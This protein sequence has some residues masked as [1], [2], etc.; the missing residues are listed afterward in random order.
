MHHFVSQHRYTMSPRRQDSEET[1]FDGSSND[2]SGH[3][4]LDC[5]PLDPFLIVQP[6]LDD[7]LL[8]KQGLVE[9]TVPP[10]PTHNP[11]DIQ[12]PPS[13]VGR[14][15]NTSSRT[16]SQNGTINISIPQSRSQRGCI[17]PATPTC[18]SSPREGRISRDCKFGDSREIQCSGD[19]VPVPP[20]P[21]AY[22]PLPVGQRGRN[23]TNLYEVA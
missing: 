19:T 1:Y 7:S 6:S 3:D 22:T 16:R 12:G 17:S 11:H 9:E 4:K 20:P 5:V 14:R 13:L 23:G 21:P 2:S 15:D 10:P 18:V 8:V